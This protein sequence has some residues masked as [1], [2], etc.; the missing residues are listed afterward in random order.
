MKDKRMTDTKQENPWTTFDLNMHTFR[1]LQN[2]PFFAAMS[3]QIRKKAHEGIPTAGVRITDDGHFEMF[4]NRK[5]MHGLD[6]AAK[7]DVIK[8]EFYHCIFGHLFEERMPEGK[9]TMMWNIATDLAINS[10][11]KNLPEGCCMPG[12]GRFADYPSGQSSEWYFNRLQQDAEDKEKNEG[13][14][15]D[16]DGD[17]GGDGD[18]DQQSDGNSGGQG[19]DGDAGDTDGQGGGS[20]P[21]DREPSDEV[22]TRTNC[23]ENF[24]SHDE[25]H[26]GN[27]VS[28]EAKQI[29]KERF[30]EMMKQAAQEAASQGWGT[31]SSSVREQIMESLK[32]HVDWRKVLR[33]FI[34]TSQRASKRS[35]PL[36]INKRYQYI[37]P[38]KKVNRQAKIAISID[39]SGSVD[40][41]MLAAFFGELNK[42][43]QYAEFTVV[44]FD[45]RVDDDKVY[46]WKKG[47]N[48]KRERVLRGGTCFNAPTEW[49]N[50]RE[51]DGHI[52]LTDM[53]A[54]KPIRSK[55]QRMW[56]TTKYH[57][58]R[59]Y[60]RPNSNEKLIAIDTE[61]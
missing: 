30:K 42:L 27:E 8:H 57:A 6:D 33:Y 35:T 60:F 23:N 4:Y 39:Q 45:T 41:A 22:D 9:M 43:A 56:M 49:V 46:V 29:A 61:G 2:E 36:R 34:K 31:V 3:R 53:E 18:G 11:L 48:R 44:P 26:N 50:A 7:A 5:F 21:G 15:G 14:D 40:D 55:C 52:V 38:G 17:G 13:G 37:H 32:T 51:F 12:V 54:P 20:G 1:L 25:W 59:P 19:G 47:E 24:D 58:E 16:D 28:E 10:H